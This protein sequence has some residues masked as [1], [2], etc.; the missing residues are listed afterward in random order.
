MISHQICISNL[1]IDNW[2]SSILI[3]GF[4]SNKNREYC[5]KCFHKYTNCFVKHDGYLNI[6]KINNNLFLFFY[7]LFI[8]QRSKVKGKKNMIK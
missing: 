5:I 3:Y 7:F 8:F 1:K 4:I 6:Y 2:N